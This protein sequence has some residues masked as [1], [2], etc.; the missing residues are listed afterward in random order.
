MTLAKKPLVINLKCILNVD[1]PDPNIL[2][3]IAAY[4]VVA[5][6]A[7]VN[8]NGIKKPIAN[9]SSIFPIKG[10]SVFGTGPKSLP[11]KPP[12]CP[13]LCNWV[14]DDFVLA[15]K[16]FEKALRS[17]ETCVLVNNNLCGKLFSSLESPARFDEFSKVM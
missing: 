4:V 16:P 15:D 7:A 8:P 5:A 2:L 13:I 10:N 14:F 1:V 11:R 12:D 17:F 9:G 6:A 3:W